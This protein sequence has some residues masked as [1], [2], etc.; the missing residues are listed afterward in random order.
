MGSMLAV[1]AKRRDLNV[2]LLDEPDSHIHR[3][4]QRRLVQK[5]VEHTNN[6]QVFL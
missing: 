2:V 3:D 4:I 1:H 5:L 6:T